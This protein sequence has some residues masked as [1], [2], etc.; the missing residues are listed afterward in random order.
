[1]KKGSINP[2]LRRARIGNCLVCNKEY[3][4]VKDFKQKKQKYC[5]RVC[6]QKDWIKNIRPTIKI[7]NTL[8]NEFNPS[9]KG[10]R[11]GYHGMHRWV[12]NK[13]GNP[14][15]CEHCGDDSKRKYEWANVDH[16]YRRN[17]KDYMRL[18]TSCHRKW[19]KKHNNY[20]GRWTKKHE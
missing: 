16:K 12:I 6:Y 14:Q 1:M 13:L 20:K 4:A 8:K 3:R 2:H 7:T 19:D 9:W 11:V 5:S 18:C 10:D 17:L 15:K